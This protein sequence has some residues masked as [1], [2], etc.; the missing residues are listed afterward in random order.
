MPY[1]TN[2]QQQQSPESLAPASA[3]LASQMQAGPALVSKSASSSNVLSAVALASGAQMG[4]SKS[5]QQQVALEAGEQQQQQPQ[6]APRETPVEIPKQPEGQDKTTPAAATGGAEP[7]PELELEAE[8]ELEL[9]SIDL[10]LGCEAHIQTPRRR[11]N[12]LNKLLKHT[13]SLSE[14]PEFGLETDSEPELRQLMLQIDVWGLNIFEVH[15]AS[16]EHSLTVVMYRIFKVSFS[17]STP[18]A[19]PSCVSY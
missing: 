11:I 14:L 17:V 18:V 10:G 13:E 6:A 19:S 12:E 15:R 9:E 3:E 5:D 16:H 7:E 2:Q 1:L 8:L 4:A